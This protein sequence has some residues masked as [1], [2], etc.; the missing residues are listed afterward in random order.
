M[1]WGRT[2]TV[3][4]VGTGAAV[5]GAGAA[6][7]VA[8][9]VVS[10]YSV[11]PGGGSPAA[12]GGLRVHSVAA[13]QV[14]L[15]RSW[16]TQRP[17]RY[18]LEWSGGRAVV[19]AVVATGAQTVTRRLESVQTLGGSPLAVGSTVRITPQLFTGD[20]L[21]SLGLEFSEIEVPGELGPLPAWFLPGA[22][23][24]CLIAVHGGLDRRQVLP[25]LPLLD[26]LK[27]PVLAVTYRNDEGAPRSPD[28]L[29]HLG[30]SE[31]HDVDAAIRF[32]LDGGARRIVLLGW[33]A[34]ATMALQAAVRS[35]HRAA[36]RG[37]VLD[38][39][40]LD[41]RGTVR[42]R[43]T[44][45]GVPPFLAELGVRAA[46]GRSGVDPERLDRAALGEGLDA[47][48]LLLHGSDD[49]VA[50]VGPARRLAGR[51]DDLVIYE[52]F[53]DAEHEALWNADPARYEESLRRFLTPLL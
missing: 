26:Q 50:P 2:A 31:W 22:R 36:V 25:L 6:A 43:A 33:S 3:A 40:V 1:R 5:V 41:W 30:D 45:R 12:A 9:R 13:G 11:R 24:L 48:V 34:G 28:G 4:A 35:E 20:P 37:L 51:R 47:P 44:R 29:S 38:S 21:G 18:G 8:G 16:E 19:G 32:A 39:P 23:A 53:P 17:G 52:E 10:D 14:E 15:T 46:L 42:R 49:T 7:L 27:V